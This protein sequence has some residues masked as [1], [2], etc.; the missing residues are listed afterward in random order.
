MGSLSYS[1]KLPLVRL[2]AT[3]DNCRGFVQHRCLC[4][5]DDFFSGEELQ[6]LEKAAADAVSRLEAAQQLNQQIRH[7]M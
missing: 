4:S 2:D 6:V 1:T 5:P 7:A 3:D